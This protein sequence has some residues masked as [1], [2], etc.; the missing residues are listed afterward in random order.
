VHQFAYDEKIKQMKTYFKYLCLAI[1]LLH[2]SCSEQKNTDTDYKAPKKTLP[3]A[4]GEVAEIFLLMDSAKWHGELGENVR[5]VLNPPYLGLL[6]EEPSFK[7][8]WINPLKMIDL[9]TK[10]HTLIYVTTFDSQSAGSRKMMSYFTTESVEKIKNDEQKY[11]QITENVFAENQKVFQFFGKTDKQLIEKLQQ[12]A[13]GIYKVLLEHS[14]D[15][16][17]RGLYK[18]GEQTGFSDVLNK[19]HGFSIRIPY[20]YDLAKDEMQAETGFVY[21]R[22]IE[23]MIDRN[24]FITYKPYKDTSDLNPQKIQSWRDSIG[25]KYIFDADKPSSYLVTETL[26]PPTF[27]KNEF[28]KLYAIEMRGLWRTSTKSMG[29]TFVSFT[30][31]DTKK[32]LLYYIEGFIYAPSKSKREYMREVEA[33]LR[34]FQP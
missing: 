14:F 21:I 30:I 12:N 26:E 10:V 20:G 11:Y 18:A 34:T 19:K 27:R 17:R 9:L 22:K 2:F 24:L 4:K 29:G 16:L 25:K 23:G 3:Q 13:Q 28:N 7:I 6:N 1:A 33:I 15:N 8:R 5:Q 32:E 31:V